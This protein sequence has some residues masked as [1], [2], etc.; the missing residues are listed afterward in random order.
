M[1]ARRKFLFFFLLIAI[2]F[3]FS[4]GKV[5]AVTIN[6][7]TYPSSISADPFSVDVYITGPNPGT[8]YLRIDLF[9]EGT[10]NYFGETFSGTDW[11]GGSEGKQYFPITIGEEKT[12]SASVQGRVGNPSLTEYPGPGNF[13]LR[14]RR[15]TSSGSAASGDQQT[16]VDIQITVSIP[17]PTPVPTSEPT[18]TPVSEP[19]DVPIPTPKPPTPTPTKKITPTPTLKITPTV[20]T[21]SGEILGEEESSPAGFYPLEATAEAEAEKEATPSGKK[22]VLAKIFLGLGLL[23]LFGAAFSLWYTRLR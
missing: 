3:L 5:L 6:I 2:F 21:E 23:T 13:K 7:N 16:S 4:G 22:T 19:T 10:T 11:Y 9:K 14:I 20:A 12:A 8:N 1:P 18:P 15:Y 17:T